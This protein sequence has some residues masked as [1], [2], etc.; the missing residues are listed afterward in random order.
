M[1]IKPA[2]EFKNTQ[3]ITWSI[4]TTSRELNNHP[5]SQSFL[6]KNKIFMLISRNYYPYKLEKF[7]GF[8]D[9]R[10]THQ[11]YCIFMPL[12]LTSSIEWNRVC[13]SCGIQFME[14]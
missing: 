10:N 3:S 12:Y 4:Y 8:R 7:T 14:S 6:G 2:L 9:L 11:D 1:Y 5:K 13:I